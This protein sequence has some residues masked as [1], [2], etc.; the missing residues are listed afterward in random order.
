MSWRVMSHTSELGGGQITH[1]PM[2][3]LQ[4]IVFAVVCGSL[5]EERGR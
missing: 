5:G 1:I 4:V 2:L 3:K